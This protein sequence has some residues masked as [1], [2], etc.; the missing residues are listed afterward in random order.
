MVTASDQGST[1]GGA[2]RSRVELRVAQA[3]LRDP[4]QCRRRD[5]AAESARNTVDSVIRADKK[6]VGCTLGWHPRWRPPWFGIRSSIFDHAAEFWIGR[7]EL[8]SVN[9]RRGSG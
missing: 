8:F 6:D 7:R 4:I 9:G 2:K 5:Y 1:C 3:R